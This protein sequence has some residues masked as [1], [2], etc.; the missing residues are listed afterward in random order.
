MAHTDKTR[1]EWVQINDP[2]NKGWRNE[3]HHC[4]GKE[5]DIEDYNPQVGWRS[6]RC[7]VWPSRKAIRSGV[8]P[9]RT[10]AVR[11]YTYGE[12]HKERAEWREIVNRVTKGDLDAADKS[13]RGVYSHRHSAIWLAW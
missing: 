11:Y 6:S 4:Y 13:P 1:P 7:H 3:S 8:Y 9:R 10:R 12:I 5:C 2:H